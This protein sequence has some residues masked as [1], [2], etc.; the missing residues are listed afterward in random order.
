M[1]EWKRGR[2]KINDKRKRRVGSI[3]FT[4]SKR[5]S[6]GHHQV[7]SRYKQ[8][9]RGTETIRLGQVRPGRDSIDSCRR[10]Q[11]GRQRQDK[12]PSLSR[13]ERQEAKRGGARAKWVRRYSIMHQCNAPI[14]VASEGRYYKQGN[15]VRLLVESDARIRLCLGCASKACPSP[16]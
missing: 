1:E 8:Y 14:Q 16:V 2:Q 15:K 10:L 7:A 9:V 3:G 12:H 4:Q 11:A 5:R 6:F 13:P